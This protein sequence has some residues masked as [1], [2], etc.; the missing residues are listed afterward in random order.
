MPMPT[1]IVG[2]LRSKLTFKWPDGHETVISARDLRLRCRCAQCV[3]ENSGRPLLDPGRVPET[4]RVKNIR[5]VGQ[6]GVAIDWT[7][8][9]CAN[10]YTFREL[11]SLCACETC[12]A[13]RTAGRN[14]GTP[15]AKP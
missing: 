6:Y 2:L 10:I 12:Q 9:S 15:G 13:E 3:D 7:E 5:L 4:V 14:P 8:T 1:E 11:R